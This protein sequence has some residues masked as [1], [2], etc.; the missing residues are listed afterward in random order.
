MC[1][2]WDGEQVPFRS[3]FESVAYCMLEL[4]LG[5]L[6]LL[7]V[8]TTWFHTLLKKWL[9]PSCVGTF[10]VLVINC[11]CCL[12]HRVLRGCDTQMQVWEAVCCFNVVVVWH[13]DALLHFQCSWKWGTHYVLSV[14]LRHQRFV[15]SLFENVV[16]ASIISLTK[17]AW[18]CC[19]RKGE[20]S[21]RHHL[22]ELLVPYECWLPEP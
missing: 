6:T 3:M 8:V 13:R 14:H 18:L 12:F 22:D 1:I 16:L 4:M 20:I 15:P 17:A 11:A 7:Q 10:Q 5:H 19:F 21:I 9:V 2:N